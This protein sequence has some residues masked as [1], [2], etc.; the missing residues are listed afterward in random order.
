M[1][2]ILLVMSIWAVSEASYPG[3]M[4]LKMRNPG[5]FRPGVVLQRPYPRIVPAATRRAPFILYRNF[6]HHR[7]A[8]KHITPVTTRN[9]FNAWRTTRL[10]TPGPTQ[11]YDFVRPVASPVIQP[12]GAI[13]T[14]PAP[15]LS[16]SEK[17][18]V[19]VD[20]SEASGS[21]SSEA[22]RPTYEVTEKYSDQ[23][24]F[25]PNPKIEHPIGFSKASAM[26]ATELDNIMRNN[27]AL[28]IASD[29]GIPIHLGIQ[30][31]SE[32]SIIPHQF[33]M[34]GFHGTQ[35]DFK[36]AEGLMMPPNGIYQQFPTIFQQFPPAEFLPF[37]QNFP[38]QVQV[39][40]QAPETETPLYLLQN[41]QFVKQTPSSFVPSDEKNLVQ[42]ETQES[43][44]LSLVPHAFTVKNVSENIIDIDLTTASVPQNS[45]QA[46]VTTE[47][48]TTSTIETNTEN[49]NS[50]P[51]YYAQIG[52]SVGNVITNGF[53]TA[54][55]DVKATMGTEVDKVETKTPI[56]NT[57]NI[58]TTI[59]PTTTQR[60]TKALY[61]QNQSVDKKDKIDELRNLIASPFEKTSVELPYE[62]TAESVNVAYTLLR[63]NEKQAKVN[64]DGEIFAG[65]LVEAKISEDQDFNKEK[66]ILANRPPVRMFSVTEKRISD[67][68]PQRS[69]VKAKIPPKSKLTFDDKT[70]EPILRVY[71]SYLDNPVQKEIITTK[72]ANM[73][74]KE[75]TR[76]QDNFDWKTDAVKSVDHEET[77]EVNHMAQFG[78]KIK[79]RSDDYIM[80]MFDD[81]EE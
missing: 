35:Q 42:R 22:P 14:I 44:V 45:T 61:I 67:P 4:S 52:Q 32:T 21:D 23:P 65:Q 17:P 1:I 47:T 77:S 30:P 78:L 53:Y 40:T 39:Q 25:Q 46:V 50:A 69:V 60:E 59:L 38:P 8:M 26:S 73:K 48:Q 27:A 75:V 11:E 13:H 57:V 18:I 62:K 79:S 34:Q 71:A 51:V 6:P 43:P 24:I 15:N 20:T 12:D 74:R 56:D 29:Y 58:T 5:V 63:A 3:R 28:Q 55:N 68:T 2:K 81:F 16:L 10:P 9:L 66:A 7:Y 36:V 70:G 31:I 19:V 80:P 49:Q 76:K 72:L 64:Q 41:E 33:S 37:T 54:L